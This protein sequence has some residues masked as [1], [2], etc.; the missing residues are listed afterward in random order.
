M[1]RGGDM[2]RTFVLID[3]SSLV[4]RAFYALPPLTTATGLHT[5]AVYGFATML[6]K[7]L[8][9]S[10]P[11]AVAVAFDKGK[12]T[13]RNALFA[14]YK[15]HRKATP[16][17]LAEQFPLVRELVESLGIP[18]LELEGYEADDIV[19]TLAR[20]AEAEG[21]RVI[22]VSGD[23]DVFQLLSPKTEVWM[24]RKGISDL[25]RV[26]EGAFQE[27][28]GFPP[29]RFVDWK[30]LTGDSS[31]N[32]PGVPGVGDKTATKLLL[33][34]ATLEGVLAAVDQ[35]SGPKLK[36]N[37]ATYCE[38]ARLSKTL[39]T[40]DCAVPV[41]F[42]GAD[43]VMNPDAARVAE[44]F[45]RLEFKSLLER[46]QK[47]QAPAGDAVVATAEVEECVPCALTE[48]VI[49]VIRQQGQ[50][51]LVPVVEGRLPDLIC[52]EFSCCVAG[53]TYIVNKADG[54]LWTDFL[55][56]LAEPQ[57]RK[58]LWDA[59]VL[60]QV[61]LQEGWE[62]ANV[63]FD[64][65]LAA[66]LLDPSASSYP[67]AALLERYCGRTVQEPIY[68]ADHRRWQLWLAAQLSELHDQLREQLDS[69]ALGPLFE[70]IELPL[71]AV[72]AEVELTGIRVDATHLLQ[73]DAEVAE[74]VEWLLREIQ[75][76]AG[77]T[78]NVNSSKQL[79]VILF[80]KLGLPVIKKTKTGYSTDA[81]VLEKLAG[82]H[83]VVD[84]ILEYRL[85]TK[86]KSTYLEGML[87]LIHPRTGRIHTRFNQTV[88]AT[89]RL[90][91]SEPNLQNIPVRTELGRRIREL[92]VPG[93]GY[94]YLLSADYSQIEL[95]ILAHISQDDNLLDAFRKS[96][97]IHSRT[98]AEVFRV[99]M[100]QVTAEMR[101]RAK[102]VNFGIVYGISDYGLSQNIG[103]SRKE[104]ASYIE[105]YFARYHGVKEFIDRVVAEA[106]RDGYV[107]TLL[108]RRR[109]LPDINS[110]NFSLRSFAERTAMN[111]PIQGAA[112][113]IV[114]KAMLDVHA[115]LK[116]GGLHSRVLLQVHDELVLE[117]PER[118]AAMVAKLVKETMEQAV[119]LSVPLTVDTKLGTNWA[120]AK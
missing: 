26:D 43:F 16:V 2:S 56:L 34:H 15:G 120:L 77:E 72:L 27:K 99:P 41:T 40:I 32:I 59:K 91:S 101:S 22:I 30:G 55:A 33:E 14:D 19:G 118:E 11:A 54:A 116:A 61:A 6:L 97:D 90:S 10:Q 94:D 88:T 12:I 83:P 53:K 60:W 100:E 17:E 107:S 64:I 104:A 108:G 114:K 42:V 102:A 98:A 7:L 3:G 44:L 119:Q 9:D 46:W 51:P 65:Q 67:A 74:K 87:P 52:A 73:M 47:R 89:G 63:A 37:L 92:F 105:N 21:F 81:E 85:Y 66:Y 13:F 112:A 36:A 62:V 117:V 106:R 103:V 31:D 24:T 57:V 80:E 96:Q 76:S 23:K 110:R 109:Y 28:Y 50:L 8:D 4:H 49:A 79:A 78:F 115:A 71:A 38:Q 20:Q 1:R 95:R 29:E 45:T 68:K 39:A 25:E 113:D 75:Q 5:N 58:I 69:F 82:T 111:T 93:N 84:K 70:K 86:L 18:S 35:V 48:E